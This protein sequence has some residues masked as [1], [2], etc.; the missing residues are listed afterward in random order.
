[1]YK[2]LHIIKLS[3]LCRLLGICWHTDTGVSVV[4]CLCR[5]EERW[6]EM[7]E[8][9]CVYSIKCPPNIFCGIYTIQNARK[10]S[11]FS[12]IYQLFDPFHLFCLLILTPMQLWTAYLCFHFCSFTIDFGGFLYSVCFPIVL[13]LKL[14]YF[15]PILLW[16]F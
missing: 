9:V 4:C 5:W 7:L 16:N 13:C 1:L 10:I 11:H 12:L 15:S 6:E 3:L 8:T 14:F 2:L